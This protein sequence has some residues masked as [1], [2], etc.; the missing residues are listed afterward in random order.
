MIIQET[1]DKLCRL[2]WVF[3]LVGDYLM[4]DRFYYEERAWALDEY[5]VTKFYDRSD[6]EGG[7]GTWEWLRESDVPWN[8]SLKGEALAELVKPFTVVRA[9]DL[10]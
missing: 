8:E 6:P 5:H 4:L 1:A 10:K 3:V 9:G 7:Y 2:R